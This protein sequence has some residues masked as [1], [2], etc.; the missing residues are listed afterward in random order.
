MQVDHAGA[1]SA[2]SLRIFIY[3]VRDK[4]SGTTHSPR[5]RYFFRRLALSRFIAAVTSARL[6]CRLFSSSDNLRGEDARHDATRPWQQMMRHEN[7]S[8]SIT[9]TELLALCVCV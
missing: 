6:S 7:F 4:E 5:L 2:F 3:S 8:A 9:T 1:A